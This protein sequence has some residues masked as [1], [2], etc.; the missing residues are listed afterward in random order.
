MSNKKGIFEEDFLGFMAENVELKLEQLTDAIRSLYSKP[1]LSNSEI[2]NMMTSLAQKFE[3]STE[4]NSQKF[5]GIVINET[6]KVLEE[7]QYEIR[8]Q[9][10]SFENALKQMSQSIS[11][12]KMSMEVSKILSDVTDMYAK[13]G[14]QEIALQ[15]INQTLITS[16]NS[17]PFNEIIRLSNE[18]AAFSRGFENITHALNKNFADF[19]NQVRSFNSKEELTDIQLE[20]DTINGN[21]NSIISALAIID[22]KYKDLTGLIDAFHTKETAFNDSIARVNEINDKFD[23]LSNEIAKAN[24]KEDINEIKERINHLGDNLK[25]FT[26][27]VDDSI[28]QNSQKISSVLSSIENKVEQTP[29]IQDINNAKGELKILLDKLSQQSTNN[30]DEL[31]GKIQENISKLKAQ[32]DDG[33][34]SQIFEQTNGL[35]QG[36]NFISSQMNKI[37]DNI[38]TSLAQRAQ[39]MSE[40]VVM[41]KEKLDMLGQ[42]MGKISGE[43]VLNEIKTVE[44]NIRTIT[45]DSLSSVA[46]LIASEFSNLDKVLEN[47]DAKYNQN[48]DFALNNLREDLKGYTQKIITL[49]EEIAEINQGSIKLFQEPI[50]RALRELS[51]VTIKQQLNTINENVKDTTES[52]SGSFEQIRE[53]LERAVSGTNIEIL[54][55][56]KDTIP[57]ISE[58]FELLRSQLTDTNVQNVNSL[59]ESFK[60]SSET[61]KAYIE[62]INFKIK[63]EI[64]SS[65]IAPLNEVKVDMQTLSNHLIE[66]V[67]NINSNISKE[68]EAH[69]ENLEGFLNDFKNISADNSQ[70]QENLN[71][72]KNDLIE[73]I[74]G[75]NKNNKANFT[76]IEE[77][78]N[79][80][81]SS[82][83][84]DVVL[85]IINNV[86]EKIEHTNQQQ[87][88]NAK[89]LLEEIQATSSQVLQ[90]IETEGKK[91]N[92]YSS[93]NDE[94]SFRFEALEEKLSSLNP[95]REEEVKES[96][97]LLKEHI[98]KL[99]SDLVEQ[100]GDKIN[101]ISNTTDD[102]SADKNPQLNNYLSK[103]DEY[104][105]N[106]EYLK[107]NLS[108]DLRECIEAQIMDLQDKFEALLNAKNDETRV[109]TFNI[110]QKVS[111]VESNINKITT[112]I[113]KMISSGDDTSYAYSLQDVESDIAKLRLTIERNLKGDNYKEFINR[114]IELKNIN[115]ENNKLNHTL[116]GQMSHLNGWFKSTSQKLETLTQQIENAER[117]SMEE[118]KTRLI[119]SE[120]SPDGAKI[121]EVSKRQFSYLE[122]LDEKLNVLL[123]RQTSEFDPTSF[124]DVTYENMKQTKELSSRMDELEVKIDKIQGYMEK[125]I[126][127]IE[128]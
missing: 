1:V 63:E 73:G 40:D 105:T 29:S 5:I 11:N 15:K 101:E 57:L 111:N 118:I 124:I 2:S 71:S 82:N 7:K 77:K 48:L 66:S 104:L 127:Y 110:V 9:L 25:T 35:N 94:V 84:N 123:Q 45:K 80:I 60:E 108:E 115:I 38:E 69:K 34:R 62:D 72:L 41:L 89:E 27:S 88:H 14:N 17:N 10:T 39:K 55:Q 58:K 26:T 81:L 53:N 20:L 36:I 42:N 107:N 61:I 32:S 90:K 112:N 114:L 16:K 83:S 28:N 59:K 120:K 78:I 128:E 117:M 122:D 86:L 97:E 31:I 95:D 125:I 64:R 44:D 21:V 19:L 91:N 121:E 23:N 8:Q 22:H 12:P 100:L 79:K 98:E 3:N 6:K 49:K 87:I 113:S 85:E 106:V 51:E 47:K 96:I 119:R 102:F 13:L 37:Q 50:E 52:I 74:L 43:N 54:S 30:K 103:I 46:T 24:S 126:A 116:E 18:F 68:F 75:V 33:I 76:I 4:T 67:E 93:L 109:D 70:S 65:Y 56:L 99:N 92:Q